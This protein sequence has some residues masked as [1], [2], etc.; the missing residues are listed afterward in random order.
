MSRLLGFCHGNAYLKA[1]LLRKDT[2]KVICES[3]CWIECLLIEKTAKNCHDIFKVTPKN[4]S[5]F[6]EVTGETNCT[7]VAVFMAAF[8][9]TPQKLPQVACGWSLEILKINLGS[10]WNGAFITISH[11]FKHENIMN[12]TKTLSVKIYFTTI[13]KPLKNIQFLFFQSPIF[14]LFCGHQSGVNSKHHNAT[15]IQS[16][17]THFAVCL[18]HHG[19]QG[20]WL[21]DNVWSIGSKL[22]LW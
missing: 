9:W 6:S 11:L 19:F 22:P 21:F 1:K 10:L 15:F 4:L 2:T 20:T 16:W 14:L 18:W 12:K 7:P 13:Y 5:T 17:D 3:F 8:K